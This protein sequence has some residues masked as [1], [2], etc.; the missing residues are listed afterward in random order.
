MPTE[1]SHAEYEIVALDTRG[2]GV[3]VSKAGS[4][5]HIETGFATR[6]EAEAWMYQAID[7][8][9]GDEGLPPHI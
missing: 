5:P 2:W 9:T 7:A 4:I 6:E 1:F 8:P 3:S